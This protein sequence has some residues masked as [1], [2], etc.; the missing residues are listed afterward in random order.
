MNQ[1]TSTLNVVSSG[2]DPIS[3]D[4]VIIGAGPIGLELAVNL[5]AEGVDYLQFD[6]GQIA[7]TIGWFPRDLQFFSSPQRI[8]ICGVPLT[9]RDQSKATREDYLGYLRGIVQQFDLQIRTYERVVEI[10]K[11]DD[12]FEIKTICGAGECHYHAKRIVSAIGDLHR[13]R[14]LNIPGEHL[15]HVSHYFDEPH[16]YFQQKLLIVGGR[17]SAVESAIRCHRAGAHVTLSYRQT[18]FDA[19]SVKYWLKPEIDW[20]IKTGQIAYRPRTVPTKITTTHVTLHDVDE[21]GKAIANQTQQ[22][23]ADFALLLVGYEM[24]TSLLTEAGVELAG[25]NHAPK[26]DPQTMTTNVADLYVIGTAAAGT[27]LRFKLFIENC[28]PHVVRVMRALTGQDPKHVNI[29][30]FQRLAESRDTLDTML[31]S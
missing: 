23:E 28:H 3:T 18:E 21:A 16:A 29:L 20:L 5:K 12:G 14:K 11:A 7:H 9:T 30:G 1:S 8:G 6:A 31:E 17:N 15:P 10:R 25:P 27:Q 4:V 22:I 13:A 19:K 26:L 2:F 24:D